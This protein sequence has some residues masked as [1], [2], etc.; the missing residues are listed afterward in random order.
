MTVL[1]ESTDP[2]TTKVLETLRAAKRAPRDPDDELAEMLSELEG[3]ANELDA[4]DILLRLADD[5]GSN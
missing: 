2:D 4:Q 1:P 5:V 3:S